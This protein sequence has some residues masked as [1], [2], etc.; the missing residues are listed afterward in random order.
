VD[1]ESFEWLAG[2][3]GIVEYR[4]A[5]GYSASFCGTCGATVPN[6]FRSGDRYRVPAGAL[7][8]LVGA[9]VENHIFVADKAVWDEIAGD[10]KQHPG[11]YPVYE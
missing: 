6:M 10:G 9:R 3:D 2:Q 1:A 5:T 4:K 8:D 11:V 7:A